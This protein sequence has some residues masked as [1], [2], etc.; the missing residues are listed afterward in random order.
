MTGKGAAAAITRESA[1]IA[2]PS[3]Y[4]GLVDLNVA[5]SAGSC[6]R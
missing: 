3:R 2:D 1:D 4:I 5:A 6:H